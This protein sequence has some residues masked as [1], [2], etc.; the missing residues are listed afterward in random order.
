MYIKSMQFFTNAF[1]VGMRRQTVYFI[2]PSVIVLTYA[3]CPTKW[4]I[5]VPYETIN[6]TDKK[7][8]Y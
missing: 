5:C 4:W 1:F 8:T 7:T 3:E 2:R 6:D